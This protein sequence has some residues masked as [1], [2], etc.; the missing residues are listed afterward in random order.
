MPYETI[1]VENQDAV[2]RITMNI[3]DRLNPLDLVMRE[4]LK[5]AL[6]AAGRDAATKVVIITG[7]GR[8]F[9][10]GGDITTMA[11]LKAPAGRDRLKKLQ[12]LTRLM[13]SLEKPIIAAVN[14]YATGA[15]LHIALASDMIIASQ[16][17]KFCESFALIG[18]IPDMGGLYFLPLRV[19]LPRAKELMMTGRL[20]D[21]REAAE[22]G[23]VNKVVP[24]EDLEREVAELAG[25]LAAGPSR[26]LAMIKSALNL[27]PASLP[28]LLEV[29]ANLQAIAFETQD[30]DEGRRS[31]LEKRKPRFTG[32]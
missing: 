9:C 31:F 23:L 2:A 27:W 26:V 10:A 6:A 32:A 7:A 19:G 20:F 22:M 5:D 8:A 21:A 24:P 11:G 14:G 18:L 17:A 13:V 1:I 30:F 29:E 4:E 25:R 3:P 12:E 16:K 28:T 15:G